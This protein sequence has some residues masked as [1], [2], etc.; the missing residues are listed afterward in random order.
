MLLATQFILD[1]TKEFDLVQVTSVLPITNVNTKL[2]IECVAT[3]IAGEDRDCLTLRSK[4]LKI[5]NRLSGLLLAIIP[6]IIYYYR[7]LLDLLS[8]T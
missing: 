3:N 1:R 4:T 7:L 5:A 8:N 6:V 2:T